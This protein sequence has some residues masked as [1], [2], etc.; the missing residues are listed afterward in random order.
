MALTEDGLK[1]VIILPILTAIATV[2]VALRMYLR[3]KSKNF[4]WD[5]GLLCFA[6]LLLYVYDSGRI[7]REYYARVCRII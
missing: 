4:A 1:S 3:I 2:V 5:D 6:L 7:Y